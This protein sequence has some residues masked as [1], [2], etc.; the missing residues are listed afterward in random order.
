MPRQ[1]F[2]NVTPHYFMVFVISIVGNQK[3]KI[4]LNKLFSNIES[5]LKTRP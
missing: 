2:E 1:G 4:N 3:L 5:L